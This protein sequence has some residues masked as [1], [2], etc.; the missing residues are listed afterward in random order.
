MI[1]RF[2]SIVL[3]SILLASTRSSIRNPRITAAFTPPSFLRVAA[4]ASSSARSTITNRMTATTTSTTAADNKEESCDKKFDYDPHKFLENVLSEES[5]EWAKQQ[6]DNCIS[7]YGDPTKTDDYRRLLSIMDSKDKI[8]SVSQI[9][10]AE[11]GAYYNFWQDE[12]QVQ[13][14]WRKT[15]SLEILSIQW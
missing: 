15:A 8:P 10:S 7:K 1:T 11:K 5:M 14:I 4:S 13:G 3:T 9:G 12:N 2:S 6:N